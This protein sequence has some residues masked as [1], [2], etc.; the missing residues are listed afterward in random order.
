MTRVIFQLDYFIN[1]FK[2]LKEGDGKAKVAR[3]ILC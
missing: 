2:S 3:L 1:R